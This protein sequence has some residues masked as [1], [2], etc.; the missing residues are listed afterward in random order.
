MYQANQQTIEMTSF[1]IE[2][3]IIDHSWYHIIK[4]K[5]N[6]IDSNAILILSHIVYWYR[7]TIITDEATGQQKI[8]KKF[9]ADILQRSYSQLESMIGF[10]KDQARDALEILEKLGIA[11]RIFRTIEIH[12]IKTSNILFIKLNHNKLIQLQHD[13]YTRAAELKK[14]ISISEISDEG[15]GKNRQ[16]S[17]KKPTYTET[18]T[19]NTPE[20]S[21]SSLKDNVFCKENSED[22][23][24][25]FPL[26]K[27]QLEIFAEMKALDLGTDDKTL[28]IILRK[29]W[30]EKG[31]DFLRD[32][33]HHMRYL[34]ES[35]FHF[36]KE[37]IAFFRNC[38]SGK[39]SLITNQ[40]LENKK[41]A[42]YFC[43]SVKWSDVKI[44]EKYASICNAEGNVI[45]EI[46]MSLP[47]E[48][49]KKQFEE[50][51][52]LYQEYR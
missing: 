14:E 3:N 29:A 30:K 19:K 34:I 20:T 32:C 31:I 11:E 7:P 17:R 2:G 45:K 23:D 33:I 25:K 27:E 6:R 26:K 18:N 40:C 36:K 28:T 42:G 4:D 38:L 41:L 35:G 44:T 52:K 9:K 46:P 5:K 1:G 10:T 15:I 43:K 39:Q 24:S 21:F 13:Y 47:E 37:K 8:Y 48:E 50:L 49:F 16:A 12:G 51:Y 22:T